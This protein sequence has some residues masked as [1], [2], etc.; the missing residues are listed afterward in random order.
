MAA[1][2]CQNWPTWFQPVCQ[3]LT[4]TWVKGSPDLY[5]TGY[6]WHNRYTYSPKRVSSYNEMAWGGGVG[7]SLENERYWHALY[8]MGFLDS[9]KN[10][11]P[12]GGYGFLRMFHWREAEGFGIGYTAFLTARPDIFKGRPF[13][14]ILPMMAVKIHALSLFATYIPGAAG[15]GNVLF[16]FAKVSLPIV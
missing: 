2:S 11:E 1:W 6:A 15:V 5:M 7:R 4:D 14:G 9:H 12:L 8:I 16:C 10:V 13:P 3:T